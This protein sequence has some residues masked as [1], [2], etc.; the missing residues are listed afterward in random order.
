MPDLLQPLEA[1]LLG[2][3]EGLTE[4]LPVSSTG[5]LLLAE[6]ALG[7][8]RTAALDAFTVVVQVGAILAVVGLYRARVAASVQGLLGRHPEGRRLVRHLV[9]AFAPAALAGLLLEARIERHLF[10]LWPVVAAWALGGVLLLALAPRLQARRANS[11]GGE[12]E[13]LRPAG[14]LVIGLAQCLALWPGTSRSLVTLLG[15]LL[16][17][18]SLPAAVEFSFLLGV[19]TLAA[20]AGHKLLHHGPGLLAQVGLPALG[21]GLLAAGLSA[22]VAVGALTRWVRTHSLAPF[23]WYR[24]A[25]AAGVALLLASGVLASG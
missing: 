3:V 12:L 22:A 2:V 24:L 13:S 20:A 19:L 11:Q 4:F 14:A 18:L 17:G 6:R 9:L 5:H 23:G 25:L 21:L 7:L 16:V 10:G 1:L 8:P 15:G